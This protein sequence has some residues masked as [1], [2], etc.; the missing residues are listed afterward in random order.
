VS[1]LERNQ[2]LE[3]ISFA[4]E[5]RL[6]TNEIP[7]ITTSACGELG[8]QVID[9]SPEVGGSRLALPL[10][11]DRGSRQPDQSASNT[12]TNFE[13]LLYGLRLLRLIQLINFDVSYISSFFQSLPPCE[14][15]PKP[16]PTKSRI[17]PVS[18]A[19][20]LETSFRFNSVGLRQF[21]ASFLRILLKNFKIMLSFMAICLSLTKSLA[22]I[23]LC[24][25][26]RSDRLTQG[27]QS[28]R[29]PI[30]SETDPREYDSPNITMGWLVLILVNL[31]STSILFSLVFN[32]HLLWDLLGQRLFLVSKRFQHKIMLSLLIFILFEYA[33]NS[34][35]V[36]NLFDW[37]FRQADQDESY[38]GGDRME[39][40]PPMNHSSFS[41]FDERGSYSDTKWY[42]N[43]T[44][45]HVLKTIKVLVTSHDRDNRGIDLLLSVIQFARGIL[46]VS[47]YI[48]INFCII[49]LRKHIETIRKQHLLTKSLKRRCRLRMVL[50]NQSKT[51]K[52]AQSE[53]KLNTNRSSKPQLFIRRFSLLPGS[54]TDGRAEKKKVNFLTRKSPSPSCSALAVRPSSRLS[55]DVPEAVEPTTTKDEEGLQIT[56]RSWT[57]ANISS[58]D[59]QRLSPSLLSLSANSMNS[60]SDPRT[61]HLTAAGDQELS[62]LPTSSSAS[63]RSYALDGQQAHESSRTEKKDHERYLNC[64]KDFHAL[65]MSITKLYIFTGRLNRLMSR[66]GL[67]VFFIVHNLLISCSLIIPQAI[68]GFSYEEDNISMIRVYVVKILIIVIGIVP[69]VCGQSLN[70]QLEQLSKQIDRI[71]ILQQINSS[72]R[73]NL[74]RTRELVHDIRLNCAGMLVFNIENGIFKYLLVAFAGAFFVEQRGEYI[75]GWKV[76]QTI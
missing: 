58:L 71:I 60:Q 56:S 27:N 20:N 15:K 25:I 31:S 37:S 41:M 42:E 5:S 43:I 29:A 24:L 49:C 59:L 66:L 55:E 10:A 65:E 52:L 61:N 68:D 12:E 30:G 3:T 74:V 64:I 47:P 13:T 36:N 33:V 22:T 63:G 54:L 28:S 23:L 21:I 57:S 48:T 39:N 38:P 69:F 32:G 40:K 9:P 67:T 44:S 17:C 18:Q 73:D 26:V 1:H 4:S 50:A 51:P 45:G 19:T 75:N 72:R 76:E 53:K 34:L 62:C 2:S 11:E 6:S 16:D 8:E 35:F 14:T 7:I 70:D 46:R